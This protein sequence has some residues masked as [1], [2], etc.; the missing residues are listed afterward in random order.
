MKKASKMIKEYNKLISR[1][2]QNELN[3]LPLPKPKDLHLTDSF[4]QDTALWEEDHFESS[5]KWAKD[6]ATR[7]IIQVFHEK[8]RIKEEF[9]ILARQALRFLNSHYVNLKKVRKA[10]RVVVA[11]SHLGKWLLKHGQISKNAIVSMVSNV[12]PESLKKY[13]F[14]TDEILSKIQGDPFSTSVNWKGPY[15]TQNLRQDAG[16]K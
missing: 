11:K 15:M 7:A 12:K 16:Q 4:L 6:P 8:A 5:D 1:L 10:L 13:K 2:P 3:P 9:E 14:Y